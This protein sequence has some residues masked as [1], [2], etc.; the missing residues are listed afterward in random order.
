MK[1]TK[2]HCLALMAKYTFKTIDMM[3]QLLVTRVNRKRSY[4]N[5]NIKK[6]FCQAYLF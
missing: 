2:F 3:G 4:F 1:S 5:N 6:T